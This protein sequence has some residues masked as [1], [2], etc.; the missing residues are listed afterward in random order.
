M[1]CTPR[2]GIFFKKQNFIYFFIFGYAG[3]SLLHR[4][5]LVVENRSY[6]LAASGFSLW[7]LLLLQS[8]GSRTWVQ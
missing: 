4:L 7:W 3:S 6:S 5:S 2:D 8:T 1:F